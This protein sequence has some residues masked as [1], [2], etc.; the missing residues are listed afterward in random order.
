MYPFVVRCSLPWTRASVAVDAYDLA[1]SLAAHILPERSVAGRG[2]AT[3]TA[4]DL[5]P[6][7]YVL[8][9]RARAV[10]A[11]EWLTATRSLRIDGVS[12]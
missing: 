1:G 3:W 2:A 8:V 9:L 4:G 10:P 6:G 11:G 7:L 5:A 12:P